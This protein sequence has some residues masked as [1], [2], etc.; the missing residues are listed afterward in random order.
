MDILDEVSTE[1]DN[2]NNE[3]DRFSSQRD[4]SLLSE[5]KARSFEDKINIFS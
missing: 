3:R 4:N 1:R 5:W 2:P